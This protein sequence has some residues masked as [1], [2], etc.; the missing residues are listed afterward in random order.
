MLKAS[1]KL[2]LLLGFCFTH[3]ILMGSIYCPP[4]KVL[5]CDDDI[6]Y[7][8]VTGRATAIG[9]P[10]SIIKYSD[11]SFLDQCNVGYVNRTWYVDMNQDGV[12]QSNELNC[13]QKLTLNRIP[14]DIV[15]TFPSYKTYTCKEDIVLDKPSWTSGPCDVMG[16]NVHDEVYEV[17]TEVCY[18]IFRKFTVLNW[19]TYKPSDPNW[20]GWVMAQRIMC[21]ASMK[22][23]SLN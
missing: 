4:D 7:L 19:C 5:F 2:I 14:F 12:F 11:V 17:V 15:V 18:K 23:D 10:T 21:S 1:L 9:Y 8:P 3:S 20:D 16:Y 13:T 6:Y 22:K